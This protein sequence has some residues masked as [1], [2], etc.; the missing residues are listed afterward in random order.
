M[1]PSDV[2]MIFALG[3]VGGLLW[4]VTAGGLLDKFPWLRRPDLPVV[5]RR[6]AWGLAAYTAP[7]ILGCLFGIWALT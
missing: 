5:R 4:G 2:V 6:I 3:W 7:I 1:M